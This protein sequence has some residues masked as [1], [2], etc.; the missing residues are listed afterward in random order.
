[1][2][3]GS[4]GFIQSRPSGC[5][6]FD[7]N[8]ILSCQ[9][10]VPCTFETQVKDL[11]FLDHGAESENLE[12]GT[13]MELP[14]WLAKELCGAQRRMISVDLPKVY[15]EAYRQ[16]LEADATAVDL[17][18][19]GPYYY[20]FGGKLLD[21]GNAENSRI[22]ESLMMA[23]MKR[24]RKLM[25]LSLNKIEN[26]NDLLALLP[27]LDN[28]ERNIFTLTQRGLMDF[29]QWKKGVTSKLTTSRGVANQRKRKRTED[30]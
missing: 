16:I 11:G 21:F 29:E 6:Y 24:M 4:S 26:G 20:S 30:N 19:F 23:Y 1:M 14:F 28:D 2:A 22:A 10:K 3:D 12:P 25:D 9:E 15:R 8:D 18:K 17:N 5:D 13:E 7:L 27:K